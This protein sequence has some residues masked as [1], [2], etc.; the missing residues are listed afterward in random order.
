MPHTAADLASGVSGGA[1]NA[2]A[3]GVHGTGASQRGVLRA[4]DSAGAALETPVEQAPAHAA[5]GS[6][7]S[8]NPSLVDLARAVERGQLSMAQAVDRL[9]EM[10]VGSLPGKLTELERAELS[11][12]LSQAIAN[13]PTLRALRNEPG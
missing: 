7:N 1:G 3:A 4:I 13:D 9:V 2:G 12:L 10:T 6:G 11:E 8:G 5:S